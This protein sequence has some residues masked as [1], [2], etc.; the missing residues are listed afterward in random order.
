ML[1]YPFS[2]TG[3]DLIDGRVMEE[4]AAPDEESGG[5]FLRHDLNRCTSPCEVGCKRVSPPP[6]DEGILS[7]DSASSHA[8]LT[9]GMGR[10]SFTVVQ[11]SGCVGRHCYLF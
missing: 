2:H 8:A 5:A 7:L 3:T 6:T 10:E 1:T 9:E 11:C 4:A